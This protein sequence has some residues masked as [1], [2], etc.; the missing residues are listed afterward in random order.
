VR[1]QI[2]TQIYDFSF[3]RDLRRR[4]ELT[5]QDV[6]TRSG[7]SPAVISKLERNQTS[8]ELETLFRLSRVFGM[9]ATEML[10][11]AEARTAQRA[12][13]ASHVGGQFV[14]REIQYGNVRALFGAAPKGAKVSR[15]EIHRDDYEV[16]WV[17]SGRLS[18]TLPHE[19]YQLKMGE[20]IQFDAILHHTYE[21]LENSQI[22]IL[23]LR[24]GKRF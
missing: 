17:L 22:L 19:Q 10:A 15:P 1:K 7:I 11:L 13:E 6:S 8:A 23:H 24:K 20:A 21:A 16:C 2:R 18:I 3:L 14:F 9:N 5:I 12:T 4:D